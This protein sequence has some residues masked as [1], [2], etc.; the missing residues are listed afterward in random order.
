MNM[1]E[2]L[3]IYRAVTPFGI[4]E[5][6]FPEEGGVVMS[7][8]LAAIVHLEEVMKDCTTDMGIG[9]TRDNLEPRTLVEF[10]QPEGSG[11]SIIEPLP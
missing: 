1:R 9:I 2:R 3:D 7:G 11:V 5:I 6:D 4:V 8:D 10:C